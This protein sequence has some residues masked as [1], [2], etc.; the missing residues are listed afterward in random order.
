MKTE[1]FG[2]SASQKPGSNNKTIYLNKNENTSASFNFLTNPSNTK[3]SPPPISP[4]DN[5]FFSFYNP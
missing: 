5:Q 4:Y 2:L 1:D 3:E